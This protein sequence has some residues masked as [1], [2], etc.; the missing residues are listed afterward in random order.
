MSLLFFV[1]PARRLGMPQT[2]RHHH[3]R[4]R[5]KD[6]VRSIKEGKAASSL[7]ALVGRDSAFFLLNS[8][9]LLGARPR[10]GP[11]ARP[12]APPH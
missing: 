7:F 9:L 1:S 2:R 8:S 10:G 11:A 6:E 4:T 12:G 3:K 5:Q